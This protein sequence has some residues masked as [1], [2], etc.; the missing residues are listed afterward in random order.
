MS[1]TTQYAFM[2]FG[3]LLAL[4]GVFLFARSKAEGR[5]RIS[6][7]GFTAELSAP[8]LVVFVVG[9][10]IFVSPFV[11][12]DEDGPAVAEGERPAARSRLHLLEVECR[13]TQPGVLGTRSS[14]F[15]DEPAVAVNGERVWT[16][17]MR[18]GDRH[19][20]DAFR[21]PFKS[22]GTATIELLELDDEEAQSLGRFTVTA[23]SEASPLHFMEGG[24]HYILTYDIWY[25]TED[26]CTPAVVH[27]DGPGTAGFRR[28]GAR[29]V[30]GSVGHH[31][32]GR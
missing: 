3:A 24:A 26:D 8:S 19:A 14:S 13:R 6:V 28:P 10:L 23:A 11:L 4:L 21:L 20:L 2:A 18:L 30:R 17:K 9:C 1:A 22:D 5:N 31:S 15:E 16:G 25:T 7:L 27:G 29:A 32:L 12:G